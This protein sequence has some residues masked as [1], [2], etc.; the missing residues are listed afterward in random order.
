MSNDKMRE[1][2]EHWHRSVVEVCPPHEK[3]NN[4]DYRNQ[5]VQRYWVGWQAS[6]AAIV[7]ELPPEDTSRC[8]TVA[9][10]ARQ[11][12]YNQAL[13]E[14]RAAIEIFGLKVKP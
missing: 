14:S 8:D 10:E 6:R 4:G 9:E 3:Y 12:A 1:E 7:V 11:E 13:D 2:F 5:H